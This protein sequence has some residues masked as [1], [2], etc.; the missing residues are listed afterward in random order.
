M[1]CQGL[2]R[3]SFGGR[4]TD[5][6]GRFRSDSVCGE[7][8]M[9]AYALP[10]PGPRNLAGLAVGTRSRNGKAQCAHG[11]LVS[12]WSA[13][14]SAWCLAL[15]LLL[16]C[17]AAS[18]DSAEDYYWEVIGGCTT[19]AGTNSYLDRYPE[20][21]YSEQAQQCL[22]R[23]KA[24][25]AA[26]EEIES[27]QSK[28]DVERFLTRYPKGAYR[29][30]ARECL[31]R[32]SDVTYRIEGMLEACE[33]H[34]E[35]NRL[36]TGVGGTAV[37]CYEEVL[38]LERSNRRAIDG[39]NRVF[40]KYLGWARNTLDRGKVAKTQG[41]VEK[42]K[43]L[44]PEAPEIAELE[45]AIRLFERHLEEG[46]AALEEGNLSTA[47]EHADTLKE[48]YPNA[49]Q[50][51]E[52]EDAIGLF[53]RHLEEGRA[54]LEEGNLST[55]QEHVDTLKELYPNAPQVQEL[56]DA[57]AEAATASAPEPAP[58]PVPE[59]TPEPPSD[60]ER[61][62][63]EEFRDCDECPLMVVVEAGSF[64][65][66]N[67]WMPTESPEHVVTIA[68]PFAVGVY[69][70]TFA[71][72]D[73]CHDD[74]GCSH[75][76]SDKGWGRGRQP[77]INVSVEDARQYVRWLS[78]KT[79][80]TYRLPS[81]SE[82]EYVARAKTTT[83]YAW[84]ST[85]FITGSRKANCADCGGRWAGRKTAP[86]GSFA[87]NGFGLYDVHGNV[88]ER[89]ED[90]RQPTYEG[91]PQDGSVWRRGSCAYTAMR[92]GSFKDKAWDMRTSHRGWGPADRRTS[93]AGFRVART[94]AP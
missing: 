41:Y 33:A 11:R 29:I 20:G 67:S 50:V 5:S 19:V 66:G 15:A 51:Q 93:N 56:E 62:V 84:G 8:L 47:Q 4:G 80:S 65:M 49:P 30:K 14:L 37:E 23:L 69:E 35:A 61:E 21:K 71:E 76:P 12:T 25:Q 31:E 78:R 1:R 83:A 85:F 70:V 3:E 44:I 52:L 63:G 22:P 48:L 6:W 68:N 94:L 13:L 58:E 90:C 79:R 86:V 7:T 75:S 72:W 77:V 55:A 53:E 46:R 43:R 28:E 17:V 32:W 2:N 60:A 59:P 26:W 40:E 88:W 36:L 57:I 73:A 92:G 91:A 64:T 16:V 54:A 38:A 18:A 9:R 42:L 87:N 27:C 24:E 74:G 81:E 82:W 34:F 39:L 10:A 89:L 45:D